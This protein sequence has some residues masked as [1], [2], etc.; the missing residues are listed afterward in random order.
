MVEAKFEALHGKPPNFFSVK[1]EYCLN[2]ITFKKYI[3]DMSSIESNIENL[4]PEELESSGE[5][6]YL[7]CS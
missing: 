4:V 5:E 2:S 1:R 7:K 6:P 3:E